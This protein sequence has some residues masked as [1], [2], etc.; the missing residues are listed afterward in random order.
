MKKS[1]GTRIFVMLLV[2]FIIFGGSTAITINSFVHISRINEAITETY[3]QL[4]LLQGKVAVNFQQVQLYAN[5]SYY[6]VGT[7]EEDI[8]QGKLKTAID[9]LQ[10]N[11]SSMAD[12]VIA[13]GDSNVKETYSNW[14]NE[15]ENYIVYATQIYDA[16]IAN[17]DDKAFLLTSGNKE[18]KTP[19]DETEALYTEAY[20]T[21]LETITANSANKISTSMKTSIISLIVSALIF[22]IVMLLVI[23]TVA[24]PAKKSG[25]VITEIIRKI[26]QN[27][28]DLTMRV[29]VSTED[30]VGQLGVGI[31]NFV[32]TLQKLIGKLKEDS[33]ELTE[34]ADSVVNEIGLS[35]ES[36]CDISATMEQMAASMEEISATVSSIAGGSDAIVHQIEDMSNT[37]A[38]GTNKVKDIKKRANEMYN[39]T[40]EGKDSTSNNIEEI[41]N[42]L[43]EALEASKSVEKIN[44]LTGDILDISSQTNLLSLNASI[45]AARAGE[46]GK[47]FAVV[48]DE[49]RTLAD[50]SAN[51]ASNIQEISNQVTSAV[52]RLA[53]NAE[54]ILTFMDEKVLKDYDGF[55]EVA[56]QYETDADDIN[57][58]FETF[59]E[60][61]EE[62]KS[63]VT[64]MN[65]GLNDISVAVD[66]NAKGVTN[67][68]DS[69]V[70]LAEVMSNIQEEIQSNRDISEQLNGEV[71]RFKN[72]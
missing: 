19:C 58:L 44:D 68:A 11:I 20:N 60:S 18:A 59:A 5:L 69:A 48:A 24:L 72:I 55:V 47:G 70:R 41:R 54:A 16:A 61:S 50:S 29:P 10:A 43:I 65:S 66:E 7:E 21:A 15:C 46:A 62:I 2:L 33:Q 49:I 27:E 35:N 53:D 39:Y 17:E 32:E 31:N 51:S 22:F 4:Q 13:S 1:I 12:L 23:K 56:T 37:V 38:D 9:D 28:G 8:V 6:K 67:I 57:K 63:T 34:S 40:V 25:M 3:M 52:K 71:S 14:A 36:A 26:D 42:K 45:E 64:E 30:E